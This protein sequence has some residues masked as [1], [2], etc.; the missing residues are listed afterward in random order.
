MKQ[1]Y[2]AKFNGFCKSHINGKIKKG[3]RNA[4][5]KSN[6]RKKDK[7]SGGS[8]GRG[9]IQPLLYTPPENDDKNVQQNLR[10][11]QG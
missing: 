7:L 10:I 9:T 8:N 4:N 11:Q 5:K 6:I 1:I 2:I 3:K